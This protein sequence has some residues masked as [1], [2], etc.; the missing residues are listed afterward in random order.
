MT[1]IQRERYER[2]LAALEQ[3]QQD[4]TRNAMLYEITRNRLRDAEVEGF[5]DEAARHDDRAGE[6]ETALTGDER[7]IDN[8]QHAA[9]ELRLLATAEE[10]DEVA[11]DF[12]TGL[13]RLRVA[14]ERLAAE[15]AQH[16]EL[17]RRAADLAGDLPERMAGPRRVAASATAQSQAIDRA[18]GDL[19]AALAAVPA[20]ERPAPA[21]PER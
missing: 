13:A 16:A 21:A 1:R 11:A 3:A 12:D 17:A 6:L 8:L 18:L 4:R 7:Q 5:E 15:A 20:P 10:I 9:G 19:L 2:T 14:A